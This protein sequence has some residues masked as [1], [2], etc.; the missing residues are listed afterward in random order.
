MRREPG[1]IIAGMPATPAS[2]TKPETPVTATAR[3]GKRVTGGAPAAAAE[4]GGSV[5]ATV[6]V[7]LKELITS[8]QLRPG[9]KLIHQE[10]A[11]RL[12][13]SRTPVREALERLFQEGFVTRLPRRGFYVAEIDEDEARELYE[14]REALEIYALRRSMARGIKPADLR[15]LD[16]FNHAYKALVRESTTRERMLVDR[17]WHLALAAL[18]DNRALLRSLEA[19]FERLILKI[20][21][22]GYRT[23]RGEEALREHLGMMKV[24]RA[25]DKSEAERML[26]EHIQGARRRLVGHLAE[27]SG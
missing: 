27:L 5:N 7:A 14:L 22:D 2:P 20:R 17:D 11:E 16:A 19:V 1:R 12:A 13:V 10:L 24:L 8:N 25:E 21:I 26:A 18:A 23:V 6:Y 3:A 4:R 15:R 9:V